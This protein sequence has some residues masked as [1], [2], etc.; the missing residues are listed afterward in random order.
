MR[1]ASSSRRRCSTLFARPR[2]PY[3]AGLLA[4][5]PR[6][7]PRPWP[8]H[9]HP[10]HGAAAR[11]SPSRAASSGAAA[12]AAS[13]AAT[14]RRRLSCAMRRATP[15]PAGT[16]SDRRRRAT[17][18]G[19]GSGHQLSAQGRRADSGGRTVSSLDL[20]RG[21]TL[22]I[23]G[24]SGC[25][26]STLAR[27]VLRLVEPS[28]GRVRFAGQD[29]LALDRDGIARAAA[30]HAARLSGPDGLVRS[31]LHGRTQPAGAVRGPPASGPSR[32]VAP[33]SRELLRTVGLD[34]GAASRYPHEFSGGQRQR[35]GIA[36]AIAL[37]PSLVVLD[38]PVSA[39]DVSIQSQILNLLQDLQGAAAISPICSSPTTC[40]VVHAIADRVAVMYLGRDRRAGPGRSAVQRPCAPL[41]SG[42]ARRRFPSL[43]PV[44]AAHVSLRTASRPAP[45][46]RP[47]AVRFIHA[48][49]T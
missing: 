35:I 36:R 14:A 23:V 9:H 29:L 17:A 21:E 24:E 20:R 49:C 26:K 47:R 28:A 4:A 5:M 22:A 12:R 37:E 27:S 34:A 31:A 25:G 48:A 3:T 43:T 45:S 7:G 19:G 39:L 13:N 1:A 15:S 42:V 46:I 10:R 40:G 41:H 32:S 11:E 16:P 6:L 18:R 33:G 30:R 44:C 8:P 2:H 38:E